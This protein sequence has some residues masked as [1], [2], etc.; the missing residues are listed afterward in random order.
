MVVKR[1][2]VQVNASVIEQFV[3]LGTFMLQYWMN[4]S[5]PFLGFADRFDL[6]EE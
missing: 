2:F 4:F 3:I 6:A 1:Y 5:K